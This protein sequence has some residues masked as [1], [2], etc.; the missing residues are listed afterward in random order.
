MSVAWSKVVVIALAGVHVEK[1]KLFDSTLMKYMPAEDKQKI[2]RDHG[3]MT[4][5]KYQQH[6]RGYLGSLE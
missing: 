1:S 5:R 6:R 4:G 2:I 3:D